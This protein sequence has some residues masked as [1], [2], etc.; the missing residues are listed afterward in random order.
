MGLVWY[1]DNH[2]IAPVLVSCVQL[3]LRANAAE[4]N[5]LDGAANV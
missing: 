5:P 3:K 4:M 2:A 1:S